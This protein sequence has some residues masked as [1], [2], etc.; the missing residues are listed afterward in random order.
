M[1]ASCTELPASG[2]SPKGW[3]SVAPPSGVLSMLAASSS[4]LFAMPEASLF[5]KTVMSGLDCSRG[6]CFAMA[7]ALRELNC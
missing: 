5:S 7:A 6:F 3:M 1:T 4:G 2:C